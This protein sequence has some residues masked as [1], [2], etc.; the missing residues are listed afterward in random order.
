MSNLDVVNLIYERMGIEPNLQFVENRWGQDLR[1]AISTEKI[2]K[3]I[4]WKSRLKLQDTI[5][6]VIEFYKATYEKNS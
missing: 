4:S 1:Y 6:E 3:D 5:D 2:E